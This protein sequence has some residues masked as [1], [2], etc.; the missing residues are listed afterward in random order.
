MDHGKT[1]FIKALTGID[2][3]RLA[4]EK[5][6]GITIELG[7]AWL[8]L[9]DGG[10]AGI[11]DVPGHER[12]VRNMLAGAGGIDLALLIVA[13][14]EG[15]MPQTREHLDILKL[16]GIPK[17]LI[18]LT[19][20]DLVDPDWLEL[21]GE[22]V[23][24]LCQDTFLEE[25]PIFPVSSMTGEGVE[26]VRQEI[27]S[28]IGSLPGRQTEVPYRQAI[29]RVFTMG[30][31]G[32]VVTGTSLEGSVKTGDQLM[33]YPQ[34]EPVR[35]R[36]LQVHSTDVDQAEAGQRTA[37]NLA[38]I[39]K[40]EVSRGQ[41]LATP[42]SLD[43]SHLLDV[44]LT[45]LSDSDYPIK[46]HSRVHLHL[47]A[48]ET[49][50]RVRLLDCESLSPGE[51]G[52]ARFL[53]DDPVAVKFGD[54]FVMRFFSPTVTVGGGRILDPCPQTVKIRD[55]D[56][57]ARLDRL[58]KGTDQERLILA[59][60]SASPAFGTLDFACRR[61]GLTQRSEPE[62]KKQIQEL[63]DSGEILSLSNDRAI[64]RSFLSSM[65]QRTVHLLEDFH[66]TQPL[67]LGL[68]RE[69]LRTRLLP[70]AA[71]D[72][73]DALIR[74]LIQEGLIQE[75][76]GLIALPDHEVK[77]TPEQESVRQSLLE[78]YQKGGYAP[79]ETDTVLAMFPKKQNPEAILSALIFSGDLVRLDSSLCIARTFY[80]EAWSFV[81]QQIQET[82]SMKLAD[83]RDRIGSSRKY[84]VAILDSFDRNK[85]T[86]LE[87]E[88][89]VFLNPP[90]AE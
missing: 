44:N 38:Q 89:R 73:S 25:A 5:K 49:L 37:V 27:F 58:D 77:W 9:P 35:V 71:L 63:L 64:S 7:F 90:K 62:R 69:E 80:Q 81:R 12:F 47:G 79:P 36:S 15:V 28:Q 57:K 74:L 17:G 59:V 1:T 30:G 18:V 82:G 10:K 86:V 41:V 55:V 70:E 66:K 68:K 43:V 24:S 67:K 53:T 60:E 45:V 16:L 14:D 72:I 23:R 31:F 34:E 85:W 84:A 83:F 13:A 40:T 29:D 4:E 8:D 51:S 46:N 33:L 19:K 76:M 88:S 21:V 11:I 42:G 20:K 78:Q 61:A 75:Q 56:W 50:A 65:G 48:S 54:H 26:A 87:G 3:D 52:Y 2:A 32:T 39:A 22:D 6:R